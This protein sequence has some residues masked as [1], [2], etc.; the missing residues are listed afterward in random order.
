MSEYIYLSGSEDVSK[1]GHNIAAAA[2][3]MSR[4]AGRIEDCTSRLERLFGQ[5]YGTNIDRLIDALE[6]LGPTV[7]KKP[8]EGIEG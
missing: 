5:G 6:K 2:E 3:T 8:K 7:S 1:A 4:A